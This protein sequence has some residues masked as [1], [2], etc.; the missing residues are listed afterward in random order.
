MIP[1]GRQSVDEADIQ[2]VVDVLRS[3]WLT[4][5][6]AVAGFEEAVAAHCRARHAVAVNSA[7]S[8][9]H[10][11]CLALGVGKGSLVWTSPNSFVASANCARMCGADVDFVDIGLSSANMS[12][13]ALAEKL[14]LAEKAGRLPQVVI[15]VHFAGQPCEMAEIRVLAERYGFKIIEDASHAVG[16]A[17]RGDPIGNG[18]YADIA[19]FS[20]H[21]V[22]II[23]TGEGGMAL[24]N[25]DVLAGQMRSLRS[26]GITRDV[27]RMEGAAD[28][29]WYYQQLGLGFNYRITD[30]QAALGIS[31]LQRLDAL[32]ARRNAL[33]Q[34]YHDLLR[35]LPLQPLSQ[36]PH[37]SSAWH[38][39][40]VHLDDAGHR[41]QVYNHLH[42]A[43]IKVN[44]H[45]I[46]IHLQPYYRRLGFGPGDFPMAEE[47][48]RRSLSLPLYP[49]LRNEDQK[50]VVETLRSAI[51]Q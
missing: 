13:S 33:A 20:F 36:H 38:L 39:Y 30:I 18:R 46:P 50:T 4:Q 31:Q 26:H 32:L 6:P 15:P 44:V 21:P 35:G 24:T 49:D 23:T 47:H 29:D 27:S 12:V 3:D 22:K 19:V 34:Q 42:A 37:R 41:Q 16:A 7:T 2:A 43:G 5:G 40:V 45:Y 17:Y 14:A 1:Y 48:Y 28:G 8:A 25:D 11:A 10:L 9:L 51:L